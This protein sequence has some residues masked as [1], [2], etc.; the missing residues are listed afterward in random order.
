MTS[1]NSNGFDVEVLGSDVPVIV[2]FWASW[3]APCRAI[4]PILKELADEYKGKVKFV[5][6][7][8][9]GSQ[10]L[11]EKFGISAVPTLIVF[12]RGS[13][14]ARRTGMASKDG[15]SK[16]IDGILTAA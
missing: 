8:V 12:R 14:V 9:E 4:A 11:T 7:D 2:D 1:V 13:E 6:C 15:I 10:D 3:C 5:K 16:E